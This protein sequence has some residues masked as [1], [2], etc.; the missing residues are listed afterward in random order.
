M[1]YNKV[2]QTIELGEVPTGPTEDEIRKRIQ[3][4]VESA[5]AAREQEL[6]QENDQIAKEIED[7]IRG[8]VI[9]RVSTLTH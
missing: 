1:L 7:E 8:M 6:K 2:V 5:T 3:A 9:S 4:E